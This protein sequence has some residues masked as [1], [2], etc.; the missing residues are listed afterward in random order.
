MRITSLPRFGIVGFAFLAIVLLAVPIAMRAASTPGVLEA[1]I[2]P[3]NGGMRLVD[4]SVACHNNETRIEWNVIGP[5]G[6]AGPTGPTG[7]TG[8]TGPT[9]ATGATGDTGATGPAGPTGPPG[10]SSGGPPFVWICTPA[11]LPNAG[12]H[13]RDD[14]YVFNGSGVTANVAVNLL[15]K[16]GANL[17]G[18]T[19][20][21]TAQTYP[22]EAGATTSPLLDVH[23]RDVQWAMPDTGA[24]DTNVVFTVRV[25]SDQPVV[26][27]ANFQFNGSIPSQCSLLPK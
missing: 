26:V 7:D 4:S 18:V 17:T 23:T 9:G 19:I 3:G 8:A 13:P 12:G 21:G 24:D 25:S 2:N 11:H 22:G 5:A 1:C 6:P 27:G 16:N 10:T 15:D 20:P 14:V